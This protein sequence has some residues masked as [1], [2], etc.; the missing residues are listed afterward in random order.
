[1]VQFFAHSLFLNIKKHT[2]ESQNIWHNFLLIPFL[3][4]K[5]AYLRISKYLTQFFADAFFQIL[6]KE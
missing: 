5:K 1:M 4:I 3:N 2:Y 6:K